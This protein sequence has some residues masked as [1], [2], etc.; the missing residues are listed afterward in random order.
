MNFKDFI[1]NFNRRYEYDEWK[2]Y[3]D[4][5]LFVIAGGSVLLSLI[6]EALEEKTSDIDLFFLKENQQPFKRAVVRVEK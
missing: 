2:N 6:H 1:E 3:I 5:D 4:W